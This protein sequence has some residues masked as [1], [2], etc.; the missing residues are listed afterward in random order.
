MDPIAH[1]TAKD[2]AWDV[3]WAA[4][5]LVDDL[6]RLSGCCAGHWVPVLA[7]ALRLR[8]AAR[9]RDRCGMDLSLSL[10]APLDQAATNVQAAFHASKADCGATAPRE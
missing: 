10:Q 8:V 6:E 1:A 3:R 7:A 5:Q 2:R 9:V 4:E